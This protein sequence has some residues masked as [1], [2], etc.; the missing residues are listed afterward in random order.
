VIPHSSRPINIPHITKVAVLSRQEFS[1][2]LTEMPYAAL[3]M[4]INQNQYRPFHLCLDIAVGW[5]PMLL[6][7]RSRDRDPM[8]S[9]IFV[10]YLL[11]PAALCTGV[12]SASNRNEYQKQKNVTGDKAATVV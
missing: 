1:E 4:F 7:G 2:W 12:Y 5:G 8:R 11:L 9:V 6:V 10:I 3:R